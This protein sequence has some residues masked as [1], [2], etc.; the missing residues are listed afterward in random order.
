MKKIFTDMKKILFGL[1]LVFTLVGCEGFLDENPPSRLTMQEAYSNSALVYLNA[2]AQLYSSLG[3]Y[4]G[5]D[6]DWRGNSG[7]VYAFP[8]LTSDMFFCPGRQ[9]DWV[10]NGYY[11]NLF[12]QNYDST[13]KMVKAAWA[14]LFNFISKCNTSLDD[15]K[16]IYEESGED[17]LL[18][19]MAE[20]RGLRAF[21]Y[22]YALD[23]FAR[24]PILTTSDIDMSQ[25]KQAERHEVF[26]FI[27]DEL[28]EIIP[29][30]PEAPCQ[31]LGQQ[32]YARMTKYVAYG[33]LAKLAANSPIYIRD[34]WNDGEYIATFTDKYPN[35]FPPYNQEILTDGR[36]EY[37]LD[38]VFEKVTASGKNIVFATPDGNKNAWETVIWC[39]EKLAEGGYMLEPDYTLNFTND[40]NEKSRENIFIRPSDYSTYNNLGD[41][42][43]RFTYSYEHASAIGAGTGPNG[44][45]ASLQTLYMYQYDIATDSSPDPRFD[46]SFCHGYVLDYSGNRIPSAV[47]PSYEPY[48]RYIPEVVRLD[49]GVDYAGDE[50]KYIVRWAGARNGKYKCDP[51]APK[52]GLYAADRVVI[53]YGDI[54]LLSA[55]AEL[56]LG[57][58]DNALDKVNQIRTRA[59]VPPFAEV[60]P[61]ILIDERGR[62]LAWEVPRRQDL[63]RYGMYTLPTMDKFVGVE[64]H[65]VA[66][67]YEL[68][69]TG[70]RT[71]FPIPFV[72]LQLNPQYK[73]NVGWN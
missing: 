3:I 29:L 32:Y 54:L 22:S 34:N 24:V 70:W 45:V 35:T 52:G 25:V 59:G 66:N 11:Q 64:H 51:N 49:F 68:D 61:Q 18:D 67:D 55:E 27:R 44:T 33:I 13:Y 26:E 65:A 47:A 56:R 4:G 1:A 6:D 41:S 14:K 39:E 73:Q 19:Y 63:V 69:M 16:A 30:L 12:V 2:V 7:Y 48:A 58:A 72:Q 23:Y 36:F 17:F 21:V 42:Y 5:Y 28:L 15:L 8:H 40:G 46:A 37:H 31:T 62:E 9:G 60:T 50:G 57:H 20:I 43:P 53:R 38:D 71:V 10:D